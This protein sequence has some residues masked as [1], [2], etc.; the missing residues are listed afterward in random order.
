M[1]RRQWQRVLYSL[2]SRWDAL[3]LRS[4]YHSQWRMASAPP[5]LRF[6]TLPLSLAS[7]SFFAHT[8]D[9]RLTCLEWLAVWLITRRVKSSLKATR[10]RITSLMWPTPLP[11]SIVTTHVYQN[12]KINLGSISFSVTERTPSSSALG[13]QRPQSARPSGRPSVLRCYSWCLAL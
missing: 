12:A 3:I 13:P 11:L 2:Y 7:Y 6:S 9:R 4:I 5:D 10:R 1:Q 8:D